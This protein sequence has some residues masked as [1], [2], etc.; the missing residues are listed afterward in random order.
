MNETVKLILGFLAFPLGVLSIWFMLESDT[1]L[2][3]LERQ[4]A[5]SNELKLA[6]LE[7]YTELFKK[8]LITYQEFK[9]QTK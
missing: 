5:R 9:K 7:K 3:F 8:G 4:K 2:T 1:A 6:K